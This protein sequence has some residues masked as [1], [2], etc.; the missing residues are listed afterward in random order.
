MF[1]SKAKLYFQFGRCQTAATLSTN[2]HQQIKI[3]N[4]ENRS[5]L[6]M[7]CFWKQ[8]LSKAYTSQIR[9]LRLDINQHQS[10]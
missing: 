8:G 1:C 5:D 2:E 10:S 9:I 7:I 3:F 4:L 6:E